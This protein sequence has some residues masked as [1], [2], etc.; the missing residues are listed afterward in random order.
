VLIWELAGKPKRRPREWNDIKLC[1][2]RFAVD[3]AKR[4]DPKKDDTAVCKELSKS[5]GFG[6]QV[7]RRRLQ[8][9][10]KIPAPA[11]Q[12]FCKQIATYCK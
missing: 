5:W 11:Y 2:L 8:D 1:R 4:I 9:A 3:S 12:N 6:W 10:R 7:L